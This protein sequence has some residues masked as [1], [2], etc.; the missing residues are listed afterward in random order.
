MSIDFKSVYLSFE[1]RLSR[2]DYA[3]LYILPMFVICAISQV[4]DNA[5]MGGM[6]FF[7][8]I[9][10]LLMIW[11]AIATTSKRLH[12]WDKSGWFQLLLIVPIVNVVFWFVMVFYPG[13]PGPNRFGETSSQL[14]N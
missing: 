5:L 3:L 13:T 9:A 6:Q 7:S 12:D 4:L 2:K 10:C 8:A 11:P 14:T 1:G